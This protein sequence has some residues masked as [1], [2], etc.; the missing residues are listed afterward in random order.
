VFLH[1]PY[2]CTSFSIRDI[3]RKACTDAKSYKVRRSTRKAFP[4]ASNHGSVLC[5]KD[6]CAT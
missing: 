2:L 5:V 1:K 3:C 6:D 4:C